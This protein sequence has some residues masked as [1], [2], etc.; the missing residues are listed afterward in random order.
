MGYKDKVLIKVD[1]GMRYQI[2]EIC[3]STTILMVIVGLVVV[4]LH[5]PLKTLKVELTDKPTL[6]TFSGFANPLESYNVTSPVDGLV[7]YVATNYG[8]PV[9]K[10]QLLYIIK[11][12]KLNSD[13]RT[14]LEGYIKAKSAYES[15]LFKF[16]GNK[17]L[18]ALGLISKISYN[19]SENEVKN[20]Q[21]ALIELEQQFQNVLNILHINFNELKMLS[22]ENLQRFNEI[23][24]KTSKGIKIFSNANGNLLFSSKTMGSSSD[25][26]TGSKGP[27]KL[28]STVKEGQVLAVIANMTGL[29]LQITVSETDF[30]N[31]YLGQK[32]KVTV[33]A[34]S[35]VELNGKVSY[36][37]HQ[38]NSADL[39]NIPTYNA[40]VI[41]PYLT[42]EQRSSIQVGMSVQVV[43]IKENPPVIIIP[44]NSLIEKDGLYYVKILNRNDGTIKEREVKPGLTDINTVEILEG[45]AKG[46][47]LVLPD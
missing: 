1:E 13:F 44:L 35:S 40:E 26:D 11:S 32:A 34:Y 47:E 18:Y 15:A 42:L 45:L 12:T 16:N 31:I 3:S 9:H 10:N 19:D 2:K 23:V 22:L 30:K 14:N 43:L 8:N 24:D 7:Q 20:N 5:N 38:A 4:N 21:L 39:N 28:H 29:K 27:I 37:T 46:D 25:F 41:V 33:P 36:I 6:L 17:E